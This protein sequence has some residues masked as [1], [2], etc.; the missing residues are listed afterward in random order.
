MFGMRIYR[1]TYFIN[2]Y[3]ERAEITLRT[4]T[5]IYNFSPVCAV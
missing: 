3:A 1:A 5:K 4:F 2:D